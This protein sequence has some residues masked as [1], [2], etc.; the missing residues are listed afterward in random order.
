LG[1]VQ[2]VVTEIREFS[3]LP[4]ETADVIVDDILEAAQ[5][6]DLANKITVISAYNT[7]TKCSG[8][9]G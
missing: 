9:K 4:G 7:N 8:L 6:R 5:E 3:S 1:D 2:N